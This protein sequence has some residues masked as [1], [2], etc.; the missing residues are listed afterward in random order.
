V[1]ASFSHFTHICK[2]ICLNPWHLLRARNDIG[3]YVVHVVAEFG[4]FDLLLQLVRLHDARI[5]DYSSSGLPG[6]HGHVP[7][8]YLANLVNRK[9]QLPLHEVLD[10]SSSGKRTILTARYMTDY[11]GNHATCFPDPDFGVIGAALG[12]R[13]RT[14]VLLVP[15]DEEELPLHHVVECRR[16]AELVGM[17]PDREL[18]EYIK[19]WTVGVIMGKNLR[20]RQLHR[21]DAKGNTPAITCM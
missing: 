4:S 1:V 2:T 13:K 3:Q 7:P 9:R 6:D 21:F 14:S 11:D 12:P 18:D 15:D 17:M 19:M 5:Q 16:F 10:G 8:L 20:S